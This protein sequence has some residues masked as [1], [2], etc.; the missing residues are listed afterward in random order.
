MLGYV[1]V[2]SQ[3]LRLREYDCYRALYCGLC[4]SMG[5]CTGQCSRMTLSY[6]F[7][8]LAA[9]RIALTEENLQIKRIRCL[10][11]P[12]RRRRAVLHSPSLDYCAD[13]SALLTYH[14][15]TDDVNDEK[16][17]KQAAS[18]L[19]RPFLCGAYR[20]AKKRHPEL[21]ARIVETLA[22]LNAYEKAPS[23]PSADIPAAHFGDLMGAVF[24][25]GLCGSDAR[26]AES[27]GSAIGRWI[28]LVDAADDFAEDCKK[29][30]FNPYR[31]LFEGSETLSDEAKETLQTAYLVH[32]QEAERAYHLIDTYPAP[33]LKEILANILFLGLPHT[34]QE[35]LYPR[36]KKKSKRT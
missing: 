18:V 10:L 1:R 31:L 26:I 34:A 12:F 21:D 3:E 2:N 28:Y 8:F 19:A 20:K 5:K 27:I 22:A 17:A 30:R 29:E 6:D 32:L 33:E 14:K 16:G 35:I 13:A 23:P 9:I 4:K 36:P 7:V 15:L 24:S 11:H 25:D